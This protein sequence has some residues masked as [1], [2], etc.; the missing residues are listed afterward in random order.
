[1]R[2]LFRCLA[3]LGW[4]VLPAACSDPD[5]RTV[6]DF[7][8]DWRFAL[9]D[10]PAWADP[11]FDDSGWRPLRLPHDW[12]V[13]GEF[14]ADHPATPGGGALPGG[15]GWYRKTFRSPEAGR[16][17]TVEF[18]GIYRNATV[19]LNG[20]EVGHRP[21]GY[22]SFACDLTGTLRPAGEP[23]LLAVRCDNGDQPNSRWYSGS[24]IYRNVRLVVA[25]PLRVA[26]WGVWITTPELTAEAAALQIVTT[27]EG[28]R[29]VS[30]RLRQR[31][32][33]P[34]GR[35]VARAEE[36]VE[37]A[38]SDR[39]EV[40]QRLRITDPALWSVDRP[41]LYRL[42]TEVVREGRTVD[43]CTTVT[44]L[45]TVEWRADRG[46]LLNGRPLKMRGVCLH[47]DLGALGAAVHRRAI[48]RQLEKLRGI[49][50][51]AIR[52]S[53]NPPAPELLDLC[54][55][56]GFVVID[57]AFDMWHRRKTAHDYARDFDAWH[58]RD[59]SDL[60][61]RDR[62]HPSVILWSIGN[63]ILEQWNSSDDS[64]ALSAEQ[65]NLLM[66]FRSGAGECG[67]EANL[68]VLL[69]RR[70]ADIVRRTDPTRLVTAGCNEPAPGNNLLRS[71]AIDVVGCNY[72]HEQYDSVPRWYPG[73]PF[74]ATETTSAIQSRGFYLHPSS[75][76]HVL[77]EQWWL[78][79]E[80]PHHQCSAYDHS[81][82]PWG[83][84]HERAW[85]ACRDRD[86]VAGLFV[87]TGF[88]YLGE[89]TPYTWPS[90]SS[91]FGIFDLCGFP[92]DAA[93]LYRAEWTD[94]PTL[95]LFPHWNWQP[96]ERIDL[97]VYYNG[98][99]EVELLLNGRSLGRR[100]KRADRLHACWEGVPFEAGEITAVAYR[101][102]RER[103]RTSRRTAGETAALRLTADRTHLAADGYDLAYVT[104]EAVDRAGVEVPTA[105]HELHFAVEG[106]GELVGVDNGDA[107]AHYSFKGSVMPLFG[108]K[109]LAIVRTL[110]HRPGPI[111]LR[112][113]GPQGLQAEVTLHAERRRSDPAR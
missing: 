27:V 47:H 77:P 24:G 25:G 74:I 112:V 28:G 18:D 101:D 84:T 82:V 108:G 73:R 12:S 83:A 87:W 98:A 50:C 71:G 100:A 43:R 80:T 20:R 16:Q 5:P 56:M 7:N 59:L 14:S 72:H 109:A 95:H 110:R 92:K 35:C 48:E 58:E 70:L 75:E 61:R 31:L 62:N 105:A 30:F 111:R 88:D 104:V 93:Y 4:L 36:P 53:H 39:I 32:Y 99:D 102:G 94:R 68:G 91:Y 103:A 57:E 38:D 79:C 37:A 49:G 54:D 69:T 9:G 1:M 34:S 42:Q 85:I 33:D 52:T 26:R 2:R 76:E 64:G 19:W 86:F 81:R 17:V 89:P 66:N 22:A 90:R 60:V 96:G 40:V 8:F 23:N 67:G 3:A 29:G 13:E 11:G 6:E 21:S 97:W 55:R 41:Q 113:T 10:D 65:A 44:G 107:A 63:E 51:N 15:V 106:A 78:T 45:R 46:L